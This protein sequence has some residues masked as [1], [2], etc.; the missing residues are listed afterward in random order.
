MSKKINGFE[1][2]IIQQ[3]VE[4]MV[5]RLKNDI[6]KVEEM[7]K[8]P[9]YTAGYIDMVVKEMFEK[10]KIENTKNGKDNEGA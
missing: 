7:G 10:L 4:L 5:E 8:M 6:E 2:W 3:G 9:V 1:K